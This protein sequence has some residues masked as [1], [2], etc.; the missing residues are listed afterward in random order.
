MSSDGPAAH[1]VYELDQDGNPL[2]LMGVY[3][4]ISRRINGEPIWEIQRGGW[5][6][7][8]DTMGHWAIGQQPETNAASMVT[9]EK[10]LEN[11]LAASWW[12]WNGTKW[13]KDPSV[14]VSGETGE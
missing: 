14:R 1:V 10:F 9:V 13:L 2:N 11:P 8:F 5:F 4:M 3:E 7:Y 12:F 6:L